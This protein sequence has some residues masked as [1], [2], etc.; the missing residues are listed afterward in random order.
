MQNY[1][2]DEQIINHLCKERLKLAASRD[3]HQYISRL[4]GHQRQEEPDHQFYQLLPPRRQWSAY[5]LA[6]RPAGM[7]PDQTALRNAVRALRHQEPGQ[8]WVSELNRYIDGI[9]ERVFGSQPFA[10]SQPM[11]NSELKKKGQHEYR[12]LCRFDP[13]DNLILCLFA[14][15]LRDMFDS[16]FSSSS[17]AFRARN[18]QGQM[19]THHQAFTAIYNLKH[20]RPGQDLY[21]AECDIR[22]FFDTVDHNVALSAFQQA[23]QRVNLHPRAEA[24]FRAY[25]DCYSFPVNVLAEA[26]PRLKQ[27]DPDGEFKWP[28]DVLLRFHQEPRTQRIGVPQGGAVSS[29]IANLILDAA[30]KRVEEERERLGAEIHYYRF[31][32]DMILISPV[33]KDC[34]AAFNT[35]LQKLD[36]LRLVYH[37]PKSTFIYGRKHWDHKSKAPYCWSG[38]KWFNCV[39]WV[40][41]VGYQVRYDG[42]V[43]PRKESIAKQAAK[44]VKTTDQIK[45]GLLRASRAYPIIATKNQALTSIKC[46][47]VAQG[48]GRINGGETRGP[49]PMCWAAGFEALHNKPFVSTCLRL[50]DRTRWK[51]INRFGGADI[52]YGSGRNSRGA[53]RRTPIGYAFSYHAQFINNNG[54]NLII[55]PWAPVNIKDRLKCRLFQAVNW[56]WKGWCVS[57]CKVR[58]WWAGLVSYIWRPYLSIRGWGGRLKFDLR[59]FD[60]G[61]SLWT[62]I[63][64]EIRGHGIK[65][66]PA[67]ISLPH[68]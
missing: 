62:R 3:D 21:V 53:H 64:K 42:L 29:V 65:R 18:S 22:G 10:F 11:I 20:N 46:K 2:S 14:R 68:L 33:K 60:F 25:L 59:R 27:R 12:A 34:Q 31:C 56:C 40:Q 48:V 6:H 19:P 38:Q 28:E 17:F 58:G 57:N 4:A 66:L 16:Q 45:Y 52:L 47:L 26:E 36:E 44:L 7:N 41:F 43:R 51:Q 15:Y 37:E 32:D 24:I 61:K 35:Y 13:S 9:R 8:Q 55:N 5:R 50:L 54:W 49:K 39:P 67:C 23:A 30:D 63:V 1:F